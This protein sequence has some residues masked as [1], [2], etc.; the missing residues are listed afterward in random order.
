MGLLNPDG[1]PYK[2]SGNF[3][4]FAPENRNECLF[5]LWDQEAIKQGGS[6]IDYFEVFIQTSTMHPLYLEDRGKI[7][8]QIPIQLYGFYEPIPSQNYQNQFG[9]D[10]PDE[11]IF[12]FNYAAVLEAVG[13]PPKVGSRIFTPHLRENWVIVQR[14]LA[15]FRNWNILRLQLICSRFQESTTTGEGKITQSDFTL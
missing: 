14:N 5:N 2:T 4:Q 9:I 15:E 12:E 6:P 8:S 11:M 7:F 1:T 3:E 10:S 13:H